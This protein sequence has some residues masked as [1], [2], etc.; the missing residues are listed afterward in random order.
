MS[1]KKLLLSWQAPAEPLV[2]NSDSAYL[3]QIVTNVISNAIK[4]T[5]KGSIVVAL[6]NKITTLEIRIKDTGFGMTAED[7]K[8]LFAPFSRVGDTEQMKTITG[9]GLGMWMTKLMT[10]KLGGTVVVESIK[11]VGTHVVLVFKK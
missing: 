11:G 6:T 1:E 8:R 10:E 2:L 7:Q 3:T 4:Y 5:N 9:S